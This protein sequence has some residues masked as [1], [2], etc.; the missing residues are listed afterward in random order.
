MKYYFGKGEYDDVLTCLSTTKV[1]SYKTSSLP[2]AQFWGPSK[3][4]DRFILKLKKEQDI[5]VSEVNA[6]FEFPTECEKEGKR[7]PYSK[8]SMTDLMLKNDKVQIAI[9]GKYTE[10]SESHYETIKEWNRN[11]EE[12]KENIKKNWFSYLIDCHAT[13]KTELVEDIPYQFLHRTASACFNCENRSPILIY[14]L[15][16]DKDNKTKEEEFVK[17]LEKWSEMLGL[18]EKIK[19]LI[20]EIEISNIDVVEKKYKGGHSDLFLIM[21]EL[22]DEAMYEFKWDEIK[23]RR[24]SPKK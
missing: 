22:N 15:F 12:H 3:D 4:L 10:Y 18:T 2:L 16:Y 23:I 9:E 24:I 19:F 1:N 6:Y 5:D 21:K 13:S 7:L 17:D 20:I 8:P 11:N 14:Q